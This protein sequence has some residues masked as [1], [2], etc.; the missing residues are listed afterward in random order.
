MNHMK[1]AFST[2]ITSKL[3]LEKFDLKIKDISTKN[4]RFYVKNSIFTEIFCI[5]GWESQGH[6]RKRILLVKNEMNRQR[7]DFNILISTVSNESG[8]VLNITVDAVRKQRLPKMKASYFDY[9]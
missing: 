9:K 5:N 1:P 6:V 4:I 2:K 7:P 3:L 8:R